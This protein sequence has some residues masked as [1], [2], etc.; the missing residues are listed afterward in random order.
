L[1][2]EMECALVSV[3]AGEK[4]YRRHECTQGQFITFGSTMKHRSFYII[5]IILIFLDSVLLASPN[6]IGKIGLLI[7]KYYYLRTFTRT[8]GTV[9]LVCGSFALI[10]FVFQMLVSRKLLR[11]NVARFF[12]ALSLV[13][14][15]IVY[16]KVIVDFS[17]WTYSHTG[18]RFKL[19]AY[20]LPLIVMF[21]I[22]Y[23]MLTLQKEQFALNIGGN[24]FR[25]N[26]SRAL[27]ESDDADNQ[28]I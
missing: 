27:K 16:A 18:W 28:A 8:V 17:S 2:E 11:R 4:F 23:T 19:G 13:L 10:G 22:I 24:Q 7:F 3:N 25:E 6:L 1:Q 21:I 9:T 26:E 15:V 12:L 14:V 5:L 20:L